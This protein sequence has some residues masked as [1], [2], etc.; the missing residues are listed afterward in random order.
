[1]WS[2]PW[3]LPAETL[4]P[5]VVSLLPDILLFLRTQ[6]RTRSGSQG[7]PWNPSPF[8]TGLLRQTWAASGI[9]HPLSGPCSRGHPGGGGAGTPPQ[10]NQVRP[11]QGVLGECWI[12]ALMGTRP[13]PISSLCLILPPR[14]ENISSCSRDFSVLFMNVSPVLRGVLSSWSVLHS[15]L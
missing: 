7:A 3:G 11:H 13:F 4:L 15:Y 2:W 9:S 1:M 5:D 12:R 14:L 6:G 8:A 10:R